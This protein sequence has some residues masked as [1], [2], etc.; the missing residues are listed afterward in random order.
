MKYQRQTDISDQHYSDFLSPK[1]WPTW[2]AIILILI[3]GH[4]PNFIRVSLG[5]FFGILLFL[6]AGRR[7]KIAKTNI[8]LTHTQWSRF[9]RYKLLFSAFISSGLAVTETARAWSSLPP[10]QYRVKISGQENIERAKQEGHGIIMLGGHFTPADIVGSMLAQDVGFHQV[11]RKHDNPLFNLFITRARSRYALSSIARLDLK[12]MVRTLRE[13]GNV[14]WYAPDQD[15]GY[16]G[17]VFTS[18]LGVQTATVT[19]TSKLAR[20]ANAKVIPIDYQR[21][22]LSHYKAELHPPLPIPGESPEAD[23]AIISDWI[24]SRVQEHPH[25]Y[26]WLHRRF[27]T[28]P[29]GEASIY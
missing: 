15:F 6:F 25:D 1:W 11:Q 12:Q 29:A 7:R 19:A 5:C 27:K 4:M 18:F 9:R 13:P 2:I 8:W 26:L 22:G 23:A 21:V 14:M 28:R 17:T 3:L 24:A 16:K 10:E 20:M